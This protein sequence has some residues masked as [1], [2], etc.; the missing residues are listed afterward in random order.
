MIAEYSVAQ[1]PQ[2]I[3]KYGCGQF[4]CPVGES[5]AGRQYQNGSLCPSGGRWDVE[6]GDG[7]LEPG[8]SRRVSVGG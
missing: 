7:D 1:K 8:A 4:I 2:Q 5:L 6:P 3:C